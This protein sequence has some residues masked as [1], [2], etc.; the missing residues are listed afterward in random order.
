METFEIRVPSA[1]QK[2]FRH[3]TI[4]ENVG[5][6]LLQENLDVVEFVTGKITSRNVFYF[7]Y[8]SQVFFGGFEN[9]VVEWWCRFL[10]VVHYY[11]LFKLGSKNG[12]AYLKLVVF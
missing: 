5:W 3:M 8:T 2:F 7:D 11:G 4:L 1:H 6:K 12:K 10:L 9:M